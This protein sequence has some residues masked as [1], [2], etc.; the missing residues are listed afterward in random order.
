VGK[1]GIIKYICSEVSGW[2]TSYRADQVNKIEFDPN[3]NESKDLQ[4]ILGYISV[5]YYY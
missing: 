3:L 2:T 1:V 5:S 4:E